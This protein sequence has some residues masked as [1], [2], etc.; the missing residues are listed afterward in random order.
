VEKLI[1]IGHFI[2][3]EKQLLLESQFSP[4]FFFIISFDLFY[5][6]KIKEL[7]VNPTRPTVTKTTTTTD[8]SLSFHKSKIVWR[9]VSSITSF[10]LLKRK[11]F[12]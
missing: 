10:L 12:V 9:L 2:Q 6:R 11:K 1:T 8:V 5:F 7:Q 3:K 4:D